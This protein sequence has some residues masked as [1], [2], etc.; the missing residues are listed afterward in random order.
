MSAVSIDTRLDVNRTNLRSPAEI[1]T[2]IARMDTVLTTRLHGL[3]LSLKHGIPALAIDPVAGGAKI[4][5]QCETIGWRIV[6]TADQLEEKALADAFEYCLT[7]EARRAA[8]SCAARAVTLL[9]DVRE[10]FLS[11]FATIE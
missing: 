3:V 2:L 5:R 7:E 11:T 10:E 1:E 9:R 4:K 8:R 6:F